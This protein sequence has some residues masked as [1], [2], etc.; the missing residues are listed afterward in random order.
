[1]KIYQISRE[2]Y[3]FASAGGLKE[4]VKGLADSFSYY[5]QY[6]AVFIPCYGFIDKSELLL[7]DQFLLN[8]KDRNI[9]ITVYFKNSLGVDFFFIEFENLI[10]K[11]SVYTYTKE[12]S[13]F[14]SNFKA[15]E[16]FIDSDE[17]NIIF[18][19][20]FLKYVSQYLEAPDVII[21]HDG[22]TGLI[23]AMIKSYDNYVDYF[24]NTK[25][26]FIIHNAGIVYHQRIL[27]SKIKQYNIIK[28]KFL[29]ESCFNSFVDPICSAVL[30]SKTLTVSP[31]YAN[32]I[33]NK[34]HD[35]TSGNF[36]E[37]CILNNIDITGITNGVNL[38]HY[39]K[40]GI[41]DLPDIE[42]KKTIRDKLNK[43]IE[44]CEGLNIWGKVDYNTS[45]PLFLFQNRVTEQKGIDKL[46][47]TFLEYI[48][49]SCNSIFVVMGQGE[50][51]F[52]NQLIEVA[53]S[54]PENFSY[55]QGYNELVALNLFVASDFFI[56]TSLWEPCGLTDFEAQIAGSIPIV[57]E[58]GGLKKVINGETGY[59][60]SDFSSLKDLIIDCERR[61][62]LKSPVLDEIKTKAYQ[63]IVE[64][65][66]WNSVVEKKYLPLLRNNAK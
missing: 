3:P 36:G 59:S 40:I 61:Q 4:V 5:E 51:R 9:V 41:K 35:T 34:L 52:E 55:I 57:Y 11:L 10:D 30:H 15:G 8:I 1:M 6:S 63:N 43:Y 27:A 22:H 24:K 39:Q 48:E 64:N 66:T 7:K 56:L 21:L 16:G 23:P 58:T 25:I 26:Y 46:I 12:D 33:L 29:C 44:A 65:Y 13:L 17:I 49:H 47:K 42:D 20:G 54:Y 37:F 45:K 53:N 2:V 31:Y 28:K 18:Q 60:Y 32:E 19:Y 50:T 62:I 14:N 38:N